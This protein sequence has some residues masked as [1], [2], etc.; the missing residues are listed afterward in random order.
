VKKRTIHFADEVVHLVTETL[1]PSASHYIDCLEGCTREHVQYFQV[2]FL[3]CM[4]GISARCPPPPTDEDDGA[5]VGRKTVI[6]GT[7]LNVLTH[8]QSETTYGKATSHF[9]RQGLDGFTL[10][11]EGGGADANHEGQVQPPLHQ[12]CTAYGQTPRHSLENLYTPL[13]GYMFVHDGIPVEVIYYDGADMVTA[14]N[15]NIRHDIQL[16]I[17][18]NAMNRR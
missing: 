3:G 16:S 4:F 18:I 11:Y 9:V 1:D 5:H 2:H 12:K 10:L 17:V 7:R 13:M 14:A 15:N 8:L 6:D